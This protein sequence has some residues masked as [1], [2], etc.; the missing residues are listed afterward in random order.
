MSCLS[1][2]SNRRQ[3]ELVTRIAVSPIFHLSKSGKDQRPSSCSRQVTVQNPTRS[4]R[5]VS[6][7]PLPQRVPNVCSSTQVL[8]SFVCSEADLAAAHQNVILHVLHTTTK[9]KWYISLTT[10]T[11]MQAAEIHTRFALP[12]AFLPLCTDVTPASSRLYRPT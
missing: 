7:T 2:C 1:N 5:N 4:P 6:T 11:N 10:T 12:S 8:G 3:P 9:G